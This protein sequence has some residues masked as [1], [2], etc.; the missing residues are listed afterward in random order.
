M[1]NLPAFLVT[2]Q[3]GRVVVATPGGHL[4]LSASNKVDNAHT[5][6]VTGCARS[7]AY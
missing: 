3:Q 7:A 4:A 1:F 2:V 5:T 6:P